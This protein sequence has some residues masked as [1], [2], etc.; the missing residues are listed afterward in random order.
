[1]ATRG[2][3]LFIDNNADLVDTVYSASCGGHTE[4]NDRIWPSMA[5]APELRGH[6]DLATFEKS[7]GK[8]E[9]KTATPTLATPGV[10]EAAVRAFILSPPKTWDSVASIGADDRVRWSV[11]RSPTEIGEM[12]KPYK[13]GTLNAIEV[14]SRGVSGRA[15]LIRIVGERG[16]T[17]VEGELKIRQLF[18]GLRSSMFI[19]DVKAGGA[20]FTGGGFGHGVGMCQ[21][22]SIGMADNGKTYRDI[23]K[24][25]YPGSRILKLW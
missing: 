14:L 12:L 10:S 20:T 9:K 16:E 5:P 24:H 6:Y 7:G 2:E 19:V 17:T 1:M 18:G 23:L 8:S 21:T 3:L 15:L 11:T 4:D 25:Y 13:L 22:G